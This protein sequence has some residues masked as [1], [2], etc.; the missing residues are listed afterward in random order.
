MAGVILTG[1]TS[2]T[3]ELSPPDVAGSTIITLPSTSGTMLLSGGAVSGTTGT[4]SGNVT[5][6][7]LQGPV[8]NAYNTGSQSFSGG[9][10]AE[11]ISFP[12]ES[13]DTASCY[14]TSNSRFTP[15]VAGYYL[16]NARAGWNGALTSTYIF[17]MIYK[18]GSIYQRGSQAG[19][20]SALGALTGSWIV[21][22]NGTTDYLECYAQSTA[23]W[24]TEAAAVTV[25]FSGALIR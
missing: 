22:C 16:I 10:L 24:S 17:S 9:G 14:D 2:G 12:T 4:F 11:K 19:P 18:N 13:I 15:N 5:A 3:V 8:F 7:N 21:Y 20:S 23:A 1:A 6:P 25:F